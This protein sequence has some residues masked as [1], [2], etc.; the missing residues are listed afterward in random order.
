VFGKGRKQ[1]KESSPVDKEFKQIGGLTVA[2]GIADWFGM[3]P[4]KGR[5]NNTS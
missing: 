1:Y 5:M 2:I 3:L 4:S